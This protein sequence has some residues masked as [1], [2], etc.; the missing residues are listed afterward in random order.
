LGAVI[1]TEH[2]ELWGGS[3]DLEA[4]ERAR[5]S[6]RELATELADELTGEPGEDRVA[7]RGG[8][9]LVARL[10]R[11]MPARSAPV[12]IRRDATYLVTGG[13]GALGLAVAGWLA[14][15]GARHLVLVSRRGPGED[16]QA[17]IARLSAEGVTVDSVLADIGVPD[18]VR[19]LLQRIEERGPPLRGVI[20]AAGIVEDGLL[21]KQ[22]WESFERVLRPKVRGAWH[23]HRNT[24]DLDFFVHFSSASSLLGPHGQASYAAANAF[25]DALAYHQRAHHVPVVTI[26]WG[27]W[28]AGMA[29]RLDSG[30]SRRTFGAGWNPLSVADGWSALDRIVAGNEVQVAVLPANW[31]VLDAE[32]RRLPLTRELAGNHEE[33]LR[34]GGLTAAVRLRDAILATA[35]TDRRRVLEDH[36][37]Q[38]VERTLG[39]SESTG[40]ELGSKQ[41]FVEVGMDS[42]MAIEIRNRLQRELDV[43]LAATTLFNYPTVSA[44]TE[45]LATL[46]ATTGLLPAG[47][48]TADSSAT[49]AGT[50]PARAVEPGEDEGGDLSDDELAALIAKKYDSRL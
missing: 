30:T 31:S 13:H 39:W 11:H 17:A 43:T 7:W 46:L 21:V 23:L 24:R 14:Q 10:A 15:R 29:A 2:P 32:G 38:V 35:P 20:H 50:L 44:L 12:T 4:V 41:R 5:R 47:E 42:L 34:P 6:E 40:D 45:Y 25:L 19:A 18:E 1:A 8:R 3:V 48:P 27:P 49:T 26:N 33:T 16:A 28:A 9:R 22:S 36:V 37:R